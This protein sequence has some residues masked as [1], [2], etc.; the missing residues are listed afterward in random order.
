M[1]KSISLDRP[2]TFSALIQDYLQLTKLR[3]STLVVFS[4]A[5]AFMIAPGE[6]NWGKLIVLVIGGFL[7]TGA[8]NGFNQ[9]IEKDLDGLMSRTQNRP[10]PDSRLS[11]F[12]AFI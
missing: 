8:S 4:A 6:I 11:V 7:V 12:E 1:Q 5:M 10:L 3:L 2:T 9:I